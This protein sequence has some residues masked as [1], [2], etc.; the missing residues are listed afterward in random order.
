MAN[1]KFRFFAKKSSFV[2]ELARFQTKQS[3]WH[4]LLA[5]SHSGSEYWILKFGLINSRLN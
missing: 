2:V 4:P 3:H 1:N 5:S